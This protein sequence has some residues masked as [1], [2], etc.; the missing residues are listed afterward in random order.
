[1]VDSIKNNQESGMKMPSLDS[2][3]VGCRSNPLPAPGKPSLPG[4]RMEGL[5]YCQEVIQEEYFSLCQDLLGRLS[6]L[7]TRLLLLNAGINGKQ[8]RFR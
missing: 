8:G 6:N 1:M 5:I 4:I 7:S 3:A 2:Q